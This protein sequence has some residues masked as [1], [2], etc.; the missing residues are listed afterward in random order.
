MSNEVTSVQ[1]VVQ[2]PNEVTVTEAPY[3][4][5]VIED[6]ETSVFVTLPGF[7]GPQGDQGV[8]GI[9]GIQGVQGVQGPIGPEGI[10]V[11]A[12]APV[13]TNVLWLDTS[14]AGTLD[15]ATVVKA[16]FVAPYS[17]IGVAVAGSSNA[18]EVWKITRINTTPPISTAV[19]VPAVWNNRL[20]EVYV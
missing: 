5:E 16:D 12:T 20:T 14:E 7:Q 4:V 10:V 2:A 18:A 17:Y 9:Q 15:L 1:V 19:A 3:K 6:D 11:G 13:N 8:Q